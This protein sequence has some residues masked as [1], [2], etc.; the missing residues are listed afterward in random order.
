MANTFKSDFFN[1]GSTADTNLYLVPTGTTTIV[2]SLYASNVDG[3]NAAQV[4][5]FVGATG[6]TAAYLIKNAIVPIQST[7]Q[8]ITEPVVLQ[9]DDRIGVQASAA[10]DIDIVLSYMEIT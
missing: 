4:S 6:A 8:V 9:A 10:D 2:K 1:I 7:L 5:V 3:S